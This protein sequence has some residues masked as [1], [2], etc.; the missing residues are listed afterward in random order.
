MIYNQLGQIN[1]KLPQIQQQL[2]KVRHSQAEPHKSSIMY[3][4][5][6]APP[7]LRY[8]QNSSELDIDDEVT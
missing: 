3:S 5:H 2:D 4:D 7:S 6:H 8:S 1:E